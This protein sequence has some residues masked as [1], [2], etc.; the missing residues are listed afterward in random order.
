MSNEAKSIIIFGIYLGI[1]G[2]TL[3]IIPKFS[4]F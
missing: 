3:L 2:L 1:P 4:K